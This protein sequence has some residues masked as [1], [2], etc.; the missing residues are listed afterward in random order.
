MN[1]ILAL[2]KKKPISELDLKSYP[3]LTMKEYMESINPKIPKKIYKSNSSVLS[4]NPR[5][6]E[7]ENK[8][9]ERPE[10]L[11]CFEEFKDEDLIRVIPCHHLFH[12][13]CIDT[14]LLEQSGFCPT[15]RLDLRKT[16]KLENV[17]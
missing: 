6:D 2:K 15:C 11:I 4:I 13:E 7:S 17:K 5:F 10:C 14:W 16:S 8:I 3:V 12:R 9:T 1:T